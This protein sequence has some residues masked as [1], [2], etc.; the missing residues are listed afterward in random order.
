[1]AIKLDSQAQVLLQ[2]VQNQ[3]GVIAPDVEKQIESTVQGKAEAVLNAAQLEQAL[4]AAMPDKGQFIHH[5]G[6][7]VQQFKRPEDKPQF[8]SQI[9]SIRVQRDTETV[10]RPLPPP[11][12][13]RDPYYARLQLDPT[14][15][16]MLIF[17]ARNVDRNGRPLLM[18]VVAREG[19]DL[20]RLNL[21]DYRTRGNVTDITKF[22]VMKVAKTADWIEVV[23]KD[24][25]EFDFGDPIKEMSLDKQGRLISQSVAVNP[26]NVHVT[27]SWPGKLMNNIWTPDYSRYS[28]MTVD[29][30]TGPHLDHQPVA[31]F[32]D[33]IFMKMKMG[34]QVNKAAWLDDNYRVPDD[35]QI[36][37]GCDRGLIFEPGAQAKVTFQNLT[38]NTAVPATDTSLVGSPGASADLK[39][40]G[41][42][43]LRRLLE[44]P[45]IRDA[46]TRISD[47]STVSLKAVDLIYLSKD[48]ITV[49]PT[50]LNPLS[51]QTLNNSQL[52]TAKLAITK[53]PIHGDGGNN[54]QK[55]M[56]TMQPGFLSARD[57]ASVEGWSAV[58]GF[59]DDKGQWQQKEVKFNHPTQSQAATLEFDVLN[60][61]VVHNANR[62]I[63][64]RVFNQNG[65]PAERLLIPFREIGWDPAAAN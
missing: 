17:N 58:V 55:V 63:E 16:F 59:T 32:A 14:A 62:N 24:E 1:M 6:E 50:G 34:E 37:V 56:L 57:G 30:T 10:Q 5:C 22:D 7:Q 23:E 46:Q 41:S 36:Q 27:K 51:D 39:L 35:I 52:A 44:L 31:V 60:A 28:Q 43:S 33:R 45:I 4:I 11:P 12:V 13:T 18:K 20:S 54:D 47:S 49:G 25:P 64:V 29:T 42:N 19:A 21:A 15:D 53:M 38:L 40:S 26:E 3:V 8:L 61:N 2:Q 48:R 65:I 9:L